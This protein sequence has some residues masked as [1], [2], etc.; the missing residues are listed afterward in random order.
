MINRVLRKKM[1]R[2]QI[3]MIIVLVLLIVDRG[4]Y[5][6]DSLGNKQQFKSAIIISRIKII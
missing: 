2:M 3:N 5:Q 1:K 6:R 4:M